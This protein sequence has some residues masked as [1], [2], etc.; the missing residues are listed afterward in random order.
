MKSQTKKIITREGLIILIWGLCLIFI[1]PVTNYKAS[2]LIFAY[3]A[4]LLLRFVF[5]A[6]RTL[7]GNPKIKKNCELKSQ[8]YPPSDFPPQYLSEFERLMKEEKFIDALGLVIELKNRNILNEQDAN[9]WGKLC[10]EGYATSLYAAGADFMN[11]KQFDEA[12]NSLK[13]LESLI[14][15]NLVL[16]NLDASS[17]AALIKSWVEEV[18]GKDIIKMSEFKSLEEKLLMNAQEI[19]KDEHA[20]SIVKMLFCALFM[21]AVC[22]SMKE[23]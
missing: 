6:V 7:K 21:P 5:W 22:E 17:V 10:V 19:Y 2:Y 9:K 18:G 14:F 8:N 12:I 1:Y 15:K 11:N 16:F 20:M 3:P 23:K 4:Y 13:E